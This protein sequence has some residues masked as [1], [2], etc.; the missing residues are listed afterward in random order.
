MNKNEAVKIAQGFFKSYPSVNKFNITNDGQAFE[1]GHAAHAHAVSLDKKQPVVFEIER[2]EKVVDEKKPSA[3][4]A[5]SVELTEEQKTAK[6]AEDAKAAEGKKAVE[7]EKKAASIKKA[8]ETRAKNAAA[9]AKG[10][11]PKAKS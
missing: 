9:K 11:K 1:K 5:P 7:A 8:A 3:P 6:A 4:S 2:G 10:E